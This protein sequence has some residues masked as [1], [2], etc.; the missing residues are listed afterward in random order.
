MTSPLHLDRR[1]FVKGLAAAA[2]T[3]LWVRIA[4]QAAS[5][6]RVGSAPIPSQLLLVVYLQGG[7]DGLN[8]VAPVLD[9]A[10]QRARPAIGLHQSQV[11]DLGQG[12][13]LHSALTWLHGAW[14]RGQV[15]I[16]NGVGVAQPSYSHFE[17][18]DMWQ[19]ASTGGRFSTGWLGRY[20]DATAGAR[21]GPVPAVAVQDGLPLALRS[22]GDP[23]VALSDLAAFEFSDQDGWDQHTRHHA[24]RQFASGANQP[25]M[26]GRVTVAQSRMLDAVAGLRA[27]REHQQSHESTAGQTVAQVMGAGLGTQIGYITVPGFD[28]HQDQLERHTYALKTLDRTLHD[29]FTE[30]AAQGIADRS[31]VLVFSEFGRRVGQ[32]GDAT[33]HGSAGPVFVVGPRVHGGFVGPKVDLT[34]LND[35][36]LVAGVEFR[37]VYA[38]LL[39]QVLRADSASILGGQF[40]RLSLVG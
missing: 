9:P 29:F 38:S 33:D 14:T 19:T 21:S 17:S 28:T 16:V 32:N 30:A 26:F 18:S 11:R 1:T 7:N 15:A 23:G 10:Y 27:E 20:L 2:T 37:S 8:T 36:N 39:E 3:P 6:G 24:L 12:Q 40:P 13:G 35:G 31:T 25:G 4:A 5:T 22:D 34:R